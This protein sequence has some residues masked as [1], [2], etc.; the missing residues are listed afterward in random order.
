MTGFMMIKDRF[1]HRSIIFIRDRDRKPFRI[2][3]L[4]IAA[5]LGSRGRCPGGR[6]GAPG[7]PPPAARSS[8]G[9][10]AMVRG[11]R[12]GDV[13][14]FPRSCTV[15]S[16][17]Q[18]FNELARL[19]ICVARLRLAPL[20]KLESKNFTFIV[21]KVLFYFIRISLFFYSKNVKIEKKSH[22]KGSLR[23]QFIVCTKLH[24]PVKSNVY[25]CILDAIIISNFSFL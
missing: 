11:T 13:C 6:S 15:V 7:R 5:P 22:S 19:Q 24:C 10:S 2:L 8:K 12:G 25:T 1:W 16:S 4:I 3:C 21:S 23:Y 9:Q 20:G 18:S 17:R 14:V